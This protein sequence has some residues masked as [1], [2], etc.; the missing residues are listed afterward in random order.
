MYAG[1]GINQ[2]EGIK[3]TSVCSFLFSLSAYIDAMLAALAIIFGHRTKATH[4]G[5]LFR[6][7]SLGMSEVG[8]CGE[9]ILQD[10]SGSIFL[11]LDDR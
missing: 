11:C 6:Y 3:G 7:K 10:P 5:R 8:F 4:V 2:R 1:K 9:E